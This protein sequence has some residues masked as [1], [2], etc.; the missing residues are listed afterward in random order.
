[1][2]GGFLV[3]R[4]RVGSGCCGFFNPSRVVFV[5]YVNPGYPLKSLRDR[6]GQAERVFIGSDP[7]SEQDPIGV[8]PCRHTVE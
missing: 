3:R 1:L 7:D 6:G 8:M 2:P 5:S 4:G